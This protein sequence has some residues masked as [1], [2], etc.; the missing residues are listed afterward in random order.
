ME[1]KYTF[2]K[3]KKFVFERKEYSEIKFDTDDLTAETL[4]KVSIMMAD[5]QVP[6]SLASNFLA[7]PTIIRLIAVAAKKPVEMI[8]ALPMK[9]YIKLSGGLIDFLVSEDLAQPANSQES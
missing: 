8:R 4:E 7:A 2:S 5:Q 3:E 9:A 6:A 1:I